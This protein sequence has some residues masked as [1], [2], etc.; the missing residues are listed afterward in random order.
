MLYNNV[1]F[2]DSDYKRIGIKCFF[3]TNV[4]VAQGTNIGNNC[5]VSANSFVN[6]SFSN[7]KLIGGI[8]AE[9]LMGNYPSW[10]DEGIGLQNYLRIE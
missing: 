7:K 5:I 2:A 6:R 10:F 9:T 1:T 3:G 8:V 4:T